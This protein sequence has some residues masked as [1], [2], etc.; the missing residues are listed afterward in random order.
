MISDNS[1]GATTPQQEP[2]TPVAAAISQ[3]KLNYQACKSDSKHSQPFSAHDDDD[4]HS[5][6]P[7]MDEYI[8]YR[9]SG[10][11]SGAALVRFH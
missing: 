1:T 9:F 11:L 8:K 3:S 2:T 6:F 10:H 4:E 7:H 5:F